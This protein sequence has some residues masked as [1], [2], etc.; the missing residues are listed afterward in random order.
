MHT[1]PISLC[2]IHLIALLF[3]NLAT[4]PICA[5]ETSTP[6][7]PFSGNAFCPVIPDETIL[8]KYSYDYNGVTIYFCCENCIGDFQEEPD[9]YTEQLP[10][11][12]QVQINKSTSVPTSKEPAPAKSIKEIKRH[13]TLL[14]WSLPWVIL[15]IWWLGRKAFIKLRYK[16]KTASGFNIY[17]FAFI[18]LVILSS[19]LFINDIESHLKH[20]RPSSSPVDS[21]GLEFQRAA[22]YHFGSKPHP[23]K[24]DIPNSLCS[25]YYRG[26]DQRSLSLQ[27]G[28]QH[29]TCTFDIALLDSDKNQINF[30]HS[31]IS[32]TACIRFTITRGP[33]T[34]DHLF[35]E[36][37]MGGVKITD[38][39]DLQTVR[40][41]QNGLKLTVLIPDQK[42]QV[43]IPITLNEGINKNV[44]YVWESRFSHKGDALYPKMHYAIEYSIII[45]DSAVDPRSNLWM[46]FIRTAQPLRRFEIN[47]RDWLSTEPIKALTRPN[48]SSSTRNDSDL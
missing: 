3:I 14:A 21:A 7:A 43:D 20:R 4:T 2:Y 10:D 46:G 13:Y 6:E 5:A 45:T 33:H 47:H 48:D 16:D 31:M 18:S 9:R 8:E 44:Y 22:R 27:Y 40:D 26:N 15:L 39:D 32:S 11:A 35:R 38:T 28:G 24:P 34:P 19:Q 1:L 37:L 12:M 36:E 25:T 23:I 29:L 30:S 17:D 42:W 41:L